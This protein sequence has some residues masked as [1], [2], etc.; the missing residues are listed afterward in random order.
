MV[1]IM[2]NKKITYFFQNGRKIRLDQNDEY[3]KEMFY[4]YQYF[5]NK[6]NE[7]KIIE[8]E[9]HKTK[10]GKYFFLIIEKNLRNFFKLPLY[11][12]F[13]TN[14]NN[15]KKIIKSDY[16]VFSNNRMACSAVPMIVLT[17]L[18][19]KSPKSLSF[20]MG[21]FSRTPKYILLKFFQKLYLILTL[22]SIDK[23]IFL[24]EGEYRHALSNY[25]KFKKKFYYLPFAVD[26]EMWKTNNNPKRDEILFVG[27]DGN[28]DFTLAEN[29]SKNLSHL[30][31]NFVS[32]FISKE[33]LFS[34]SYV[35]TGSWGNPKLSDSQLRELY[36]KAK[37]T[38]IPL[39]ESLQPSGQSVAL[40]SIA[41]GTPVLITKT[42]G[43]WDNENFKDKE[44]I[45]FALNNE[46]EY[47]VKTIIEIMNLDSITFNKVVSNGIE[48]VKKNYNL[49]QFSKMVEKIMIE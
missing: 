37:L 5:K 28:R 9:T 43:F 31:F 23:F 11:W 36:Q 13:I 19:G 8:F 33:N 44:N 24:S 1:E 4:G 40:Q 48:T 39:K 15:L 38:I 12:S 20:V 42:A 47:W 49:N 7:T 25:S 35:F 22:K 3:A 32:E 16:L 6:G 18:L 41:C 10:F 17:K 21:L 2:K 34:N 29:I 46:Y 45:F 14:K 26:L 27:N 30:K